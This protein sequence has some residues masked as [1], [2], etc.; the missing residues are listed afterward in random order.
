MRRR[1]RSG[2]PLPLPRTPN[3]T[4]TDRQTWRRR[5]PNRAPDRRCRAHWTAAALIGRPNACAALP[6]QTEDIT[7]AVRR[8][9]QA[10]PDAPTS[11]KNAL[12]PAERD[13]RVN[14]LRTISNNVMREHPCASDR[15]RAL[16][17]HAQRHCWNSSVIITL[18]GTCEHILDVGKRYASTRPLALP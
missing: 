1:R 2:H 16:S 10:T 9:R 4:A 18:G 17:L 6:I 12:T 13:R 7:C 11:W 14:A 15:R 8:W 5:C 3:N